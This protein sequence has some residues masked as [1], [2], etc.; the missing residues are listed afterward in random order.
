MKLVQDFQITVYML[1]VKEK[2]PSH[3]AKIGLLEYLYYLYLEIQAHT[4]R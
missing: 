2:C 4:S 1:M 3:Y